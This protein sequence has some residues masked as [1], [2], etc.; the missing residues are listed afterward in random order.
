MTFTFGV[1]FIIDNITTKYWEEDYLIQT[2]KWYTKDNSFLSRFPFEEDIINEHGN[3]IYVI[4]LDRQHQILNIQS[5]HKTFHSPISE[6][7]ISKIFKQSL[8]KHR[9][10]SY[11]YILTEQED[12]YSLTITDISG[13]KG[14]IYKIL[15][16][17]FLFT[18]GFSILLMVSIFL[19]KF[20][21]EP[22]EKALEREKQFISDV[23]HELK[24]PLA[25][26]SINAQALQ[27]DMGNSKH[28]QYILSETKRMDTLIQKL[29]KLA[30]TDEI[31]TKVD[32]KDFSL[33]QCCEEMVLSLESNIFEKGLQ[34]DYQIED[35]I[36]YYGNED[37]IKQV[38][39]ILLDNAMKHASEKGYIF[40]KL[41]LCNHSPII[42]I[43]N[44]GQGISPEDLPHIFERFYR[45]DKSRT[46][47]NNSYGL[48][49]AIAKSIIEAHNA[50]ITATSNYGK[51]VC[52]TIKF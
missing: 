31:G 6:A 52:F 48:G 49:L 39:T 42:T 11:L 1:L 17:I 12:G 2:L 10:K 38:I 5:S 7:D 27:V 9:F 47:D 15:G 8:D 30:Y 20:I 36:S 41:K 23:S 4:N 24:T 26:I 51:D 40:L 13:G 21:T 46:D 16:D 29:L 43:K 28:L 37:D 44:T 45:V 50:T 22:A 35:N 18:V 34:F 3:P 19:S 32:K 33:S 14:Q 25:A